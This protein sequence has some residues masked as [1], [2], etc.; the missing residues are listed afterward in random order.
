[1][2]VIFVDELGEVEIEGDVPT[3][4]EAELILKTI[5]A[6][7]AQTRRQP[8]PTAPSPPP[9]ALYPT[10]ESAIAADVAREAEQATR[11]AID[12]RMKLVAEFGDV[13]AYRK[14]LAGSHFGLGDVLQAKGK[15]DEAEQAYRNAIAIREVLG[16]EL[17]N[18]PEYRRG[19]AA[20]H[21][22]LAIL[23]EKK[24]QG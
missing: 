5:D 18:V 4:D 13:P 14:V 21:N 12:L 10:M 2:G 19:L 15:F 3:P 6:V 22:N 7:E 11:R 8:T 20:S 1:M 23:L 17:P 9:A 24:R 16:G